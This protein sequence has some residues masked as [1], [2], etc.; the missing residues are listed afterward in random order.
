MTNP[1][2]PAIPP[3]VLAEMYNN[4]DG[5]MN[6]RKRVNAATLATYVLSLLVRRLAYLEGEA[7]RTC[8]WTQDRH[9]DYST[10]CKQERMMWNKP[11]AFCPYCGH[12]VVAAAEGEG[13]G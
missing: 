6:N 12:R 11:P 9:H 2:P 1:I 10:G 13:I 7:A 5:L 8:E 4:A 3:D